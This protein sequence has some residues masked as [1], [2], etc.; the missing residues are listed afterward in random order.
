[1]TTFFSFLKQHKLPPREAL[2][3]L[4][5]SPLSWASA[6]LYALGGL[7][8][9]FLYWFL[10]AVNNHFLVPIPAR[11]GVITEGVIGAPQF[12]N[13]L[14]ASTETDVGLVKLLYSGLVSSTAD[15][16]VTPVL[17]TRYDISPNNTVY[18]FTLRPNLKWSDGK[19]F[20]AEDIAFTFEKLKDSN[21]N[22]TSAD[23]W[24]S[25]TVATTP[26]TV[27][28]TLPSPDTTFL[29]HATI[30]I[31]PKH[32]WAAV[33]AESFESDVH[34]LRPVG[35]GPFAFVSLDT[36]SEVP[37]QITLKRNTHYPIRKPYIDELSVIFFANQESLLAG[38]E[39]GDIDT[40]LDATP[41]TAAI[42]AEITISR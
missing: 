15:G 12:I 25:I 21:F 26:T 39:N 33:P 8:I 29:S 22:R 19:P 35:S 5:N 42:L 37:T 31:L 28:F 13:P 6:T 40:T 23:Y 16:S 20:T 38:L 18:T 4:L 24:Q 10:V 34:N 3:S 36:Q 7:T 41:Q 32:I 9:I 30:G 1:M 27:T 2:S 11:G 17:A 14:L